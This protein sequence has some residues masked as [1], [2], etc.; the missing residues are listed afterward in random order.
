MLDLRPIGKLVL[1]MTC[2]NYLNQT[3]KFALYLCRIL[4]YLKTIS[5]EF[6]TKANR[7]CNENQNDR[8]S[9]YL[10]DYPSLSGQDTFECHVSGWLSAMGQNSNLTKI[11]K[12]LMMSRIFQIQLTII[13]LFVH[14]DTLPIGY[15]FEVIVLI[16]C[17]AQ[18]FLEMYLQYDKY[19]SKYLQ[20]SMEDDTDNDEPDSP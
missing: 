17:I 19:Y 11:E 16:C 18:A 4:Y 13:A 2:L 6:V 8:V 1:L 5:S 10:F 20:W 15:S 12:Y 3:A 9:N 14:L 7:D